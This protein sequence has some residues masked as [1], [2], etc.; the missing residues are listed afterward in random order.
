MNI[1]ISLLTPET[2]ELYFNK[3]SVFHSGVVCSLMHTNKTKL[4]G[5]SPQSELYRLTERPPL[6]G[7]VSA[8]FSG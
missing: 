5:F 7:E 6:V 8:H 2:V 1:R 3:G 4:R